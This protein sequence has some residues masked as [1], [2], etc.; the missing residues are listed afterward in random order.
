MN[1]TTPRCAACAH[2]RRT[3]QRPSAQG[4]P[5]L[6]DDSGHWLPPKRW[7][8]ASQMRKETRSCC[9]GVAR[10]GSAGKVDGAISD[11]VPLSICIPP[12]SFDG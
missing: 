12:V 3:R 9:Q 11:H 6:A 1:R 5:Q 7:P 4:T 2:T 10:A 8:F